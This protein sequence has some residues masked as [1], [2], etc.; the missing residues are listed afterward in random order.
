MIE[1]LYPLLM[2][3]VLDSDKE[4][5]GYDPQSYRRNTQRIFK[6]HLEEYEKNLKNN[7]QSENKSVY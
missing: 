5:T 7:L 2:M 6:K 1:A 3:S 4:T